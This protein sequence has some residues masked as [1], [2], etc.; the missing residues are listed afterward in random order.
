MLCWSAITGSHWIVSELDL[1]AAT[2]VLNVAVGAEV[3]YANERVSASVAVGISILL[4]DQVLDSRGT[5]GVYVALRPAGLR[6]AVRR[7]AV[8]QVDLLSLVVEAPVLRY[9]V[10]VEIQYR[11]SITVEYGR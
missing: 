2:G 6:Y 1:R 4:S 7:H 10:L 9:P 3:L 11:A 5:T 8:V